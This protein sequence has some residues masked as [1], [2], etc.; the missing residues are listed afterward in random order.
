MFEGLKN[1]NFGGIIIYGFYLLFN[2]FLIFFSADYQS[3]K[4]LDQ[5]RKHP[6]NNLK[7]TFKKF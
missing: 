6:L 3:L 4:Q 2:I 1:C 5:Y 7:I